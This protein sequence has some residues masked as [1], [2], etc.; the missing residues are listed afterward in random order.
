M[1]IKLNKYFTDSTIYMAKHLEHEC[2]DVNS[3]PIFCKT[4]TMKHG[5]FIHSIEKYFIIT[6][7][8]RIMCWIKLGLKNIHGSYV[9]YPLVGREI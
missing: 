6:I 3:C 4:I 2:N 5:L 1:I 7:C 8:T 9:V